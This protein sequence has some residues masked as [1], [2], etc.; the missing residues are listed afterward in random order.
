MQNCE[1]PLVPLIPHVFVVETRVLSPFFKSDMVK[2]T[3]TA[4]LYTDRGAALAAA[5]LAFDGAMPEAPEKAEMVGPF[6]EG[7][8]VVVQVT[9][10]TGERVLRLRMRNWR[11]RYEPEEDE[12]PPNLSGWERCHSLYESDDERA[13]AAHYRE[14]DTL[15]IACFLWCIR[16]LPGRRIPRDVLKLVVKRVRASRRSLMVGSWS[17][18]PARMYVC[19]VAML[20]ADPQSALWEE[21]RIVAADSDAEA[22]GI[23]RLLFAQCV[24]LRW[25]G[26]FW[27][28]VLK[29][30]GEEGPQGELEKPP[31]IPQWL[32]FRHS[33]IDCFSVD[34]LRWLW[35]FGSVKNK[36]C[37]RLLH[38]P[39]VMELTRQGKVVYRLPHF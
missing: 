31:R 3:Q 34:M 30:Q 18:T 17:G 13:H 5:Q 27:E 20:G 8:V 26:G 23:A 19:H 32:H 14:E 4:H 29:S 10:A 24:D 12:S 15:S 1:L 6:V 33:T 35:G 22:A 21:R 9:A 2:V 38:G 11:E 39:A 36:L 28:M 7:G 25:E 16:Q 37:T